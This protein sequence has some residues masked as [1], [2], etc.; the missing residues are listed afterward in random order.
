MLMMKKILKK[1]YS[2]EVLE[3]LSTNIPRLMG[4]MN[5]L[6]IH[7]ILF[8][9]SYLLIFLG[10]NEE[11]IFDL[12]TNIVSLEAIYLSIFLL[13]SGNLQLKKLHDVATN[14]H[15][16]AT[17]VKEIQ[18][19]VDEIQDDIDEIQED[20]DEIQEDQ[21]DDEILNKI[22]TTL[23]ILINEVAELKKRKK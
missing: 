2:D 10:F 11:K 19:D 18:E 12:L 5:S 7:T 20:I 16:V 21:E 9:L 1:L 22:D 4:S 23:N 6:I 13:M 14:V 8:L 17:N 15:D 3:Y